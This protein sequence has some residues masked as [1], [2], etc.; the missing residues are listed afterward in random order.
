MN[1]L[2]M[3]IDVGNTHIVV[4]LYRESE[5]LEHWRITSNPDTTTDELG[6]LL[7]SLLTSRQIQPNQVK[8]AIVASVVPS[9]MHATR[10]A[11]RRYFSITPRFVDSQSQLDMPILIDNPN[12]VGAD[13]LVNAV[14]AFHKYSSAC[15]IVD[16]GTATTFDIVNSKGEYEGGVIAPG[17]GISLDAL[18]RRASKLPRVEIVK[19]KSAIGKSTVTSMQSGIIYGF[20]GLVD[21]VVGRIIAEL[22]DENIKIVATGGL[23]AL[24]SAESA[25]I[26]E[27]DPFLTLDGLQL[28]YARQ[29]FS[30]PS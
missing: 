21:G 24:I 8:D 6:A 9:L 15:I 29:R 12:E 17:V 2:L 3:V 4:G 25:Y 22:D 27:V 16:L 30:A 19:P 28:I 13:R 26:D 18:F 11:C 14:A 5:L 20:V 10:R 1:D 23:A 7:L